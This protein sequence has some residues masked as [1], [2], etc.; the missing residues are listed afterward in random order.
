[1]ADEF[2]DMPE[3]IE[4]RLEEVERLL[5]HEVG[6]NAETGAAAAE[7][8]EKAWELARTLEI[9]V[10]ELEKRIGDLQSR[11]ERLEARPPKGR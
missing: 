8:A 3:T 5:E 9:I 1:M 7:P 4:E 6:P 10:I 11:I 2:E